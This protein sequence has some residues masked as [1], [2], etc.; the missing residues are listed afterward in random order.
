[1]AL[2]LSGWALAVL[3]FLVETPLTH[4]ETAVDGRA[5]AD[6]SQGQNWLSVGR[7]Y[8]EAHYSPLASITERNIKE[9]GLAWY[10]DLPDEGALQAT[11][12]AVNGVLYFSGMTGKVYAVD[13]QSGQQLWVFDPDLV[14][15][16]FVS[17]NAI[18]TCNRGVAYW[19]GRVYVGTFDGRL[20][21]LEGK[22]GRVTWSVQTFDEPDKHKTIS[23][24]PR[25]F[26]GKVI[27]GHGGEVVNGSGT[28]GYVTTYDAQTGR[29]LWRFY[30]V[31]GN[32]AEGF[33]NAAM[34]QA[35]KTWT[36]DWWKRGGNATVWD[37]ITYDP[38]LNRV[39]LATANGTPLGA[40]HGPVGDNLF[41]SSIVAVD[42]DTG[43][44]VWHYQVNPGD[45]WEYDATAQ[46]ILADVEIDGRPRKVL[47]QA[48]K[49]GF[50]YVID[51]FNGRLISAAK[52]GKATWASR[53]DVN[54]GRPV[55]VPG[56]RDKD[57]PIVVWPSGFGM[58]NWQ[59][60]SFDPAT[61]LA[62]IPTMKLGMRIGLGGFDFSPI[63]PGDGT[64]S[65]LA[66]D[67]I[68]QQKRWEVPLNESFW[69]GGTLATGGNLVFQGTGSGHFNAYRATSGDKLWDFY[70]GL[71]INAAPITYLVG[72]VQYVSVLVGYGG[73]VNMSRVHDYGWRY[74]EQTRR[75]LTFALGHKAQ[76]PPGKPPRT[77]T[78]AV[79]DSS[80]V[81]DEKL[82]ESGA[83]L[84][85]HNCVGCHGLVMHNIASFA[86]DLRESSVALSW[87]S[88]NSVVHGGAL[89][90]LGMP[91]FDNLSDQDVR[92]LYMYARQQARVALHSTK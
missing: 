50:F 68:R 4:A 33:E 84:Y 30:T 79:D 36:G 15:H 5:I 40:K 32:P 64:A 11:P 9:L 6:E 58:H 54:N 82:A 53:I 13:A 34:A 75:V 37:S 66:W 49:N 47:M 60:M 26:N 69:N 92:A 10:L 74:G 25:V 23:G 2:R 16:P 39:Y 21:A 1:M 87:D 89:M 52:L 8:S 22:T 7:T 71:G 59:A 14:N 38:D 77:T 31:P 43:Q 70:A 29:K 56:V 45:M 88:F 51:R 42:A 67:P 28:R 81:I 61:R 63:E 12:L 65:L 72:G 3:C 76:L 27:I 18:L 85:Y 83:E 20:V 86:R 78:N 73:S 35:A 24:A 48:P 55:E 19:G 90:P 80:L 17:A 57:R 44:Y 41:V 46:M 62:Y 91:R